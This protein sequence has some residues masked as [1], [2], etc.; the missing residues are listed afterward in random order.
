M[1]IKINGYPFVDSIQHESGVYIVITFT[2]FDETDYKLLYIGQSQ[3]VRYRLMYHEQEASWRQHKHQGI[4]C[5]AYYCNE[6]ERIRI[7]GEILNQYNPV[8]NKPS[9]GSF[10]TRHLLRRSA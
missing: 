8:C 7:E 3:D 1:Q 5:L 9:V 2:D 10:I 4:V 6:A